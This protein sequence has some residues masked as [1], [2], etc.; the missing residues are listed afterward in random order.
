MKRKK[1]ERDGMQPKQERG[2]DASTP[3]WHVLRISRS[4]IK[5]MAVLT[6][7]AEEEMGESIRSACLKK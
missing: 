3:S 2:R 6:Y 5:R 1:G 4:S 7:I